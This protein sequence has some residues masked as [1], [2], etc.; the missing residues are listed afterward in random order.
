MSTQAYSYDDNVRREDLLDLITN[1]TPQ[2]TQ[3]FSG[4]GTSEAKA[5]LHEWGKDTL[6]SAG[7]NAQVE[8]ADATDRTLTNPERLTNHTQIMSKVYKVSETSRAIDSAGFEDRLAYEADKA[9]RS[10]ANDIEFAL[11]RGSLA[12]GTGSAARQLKGV[13]RWFA[14]NNYT[15]QSGV[16][17]SEDMFN[18]MLQDVWDDGTMVN[19]VYVPMTLKRRISGFTAGSTKNVD[20]A[21]KRLFNAVDIY[22]ADAAQNVKLFAHRY[23]TQSGDVNNSVVGINEDMFKIAYLRRPVTQPLAKTGDFTREQVISELTLECYHED[24]GF[25]LDQVY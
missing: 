10:L 3:L 12:C 15:A 20:A 22:Q 18:E 11:M 23:V 13:K 7:T 5:I 19:A 16:S 25:H 21:D 24:A 17:L 6:D 8:G 1:L 9:F 2:E 14:S 4:L